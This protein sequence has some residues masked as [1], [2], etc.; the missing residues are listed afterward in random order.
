MP[1]LENRNSKSENRKSKVENRLMVIPAQAGI[2][3]LTG[4]RFLGATFR[5]AS[6]EFRVSNFDFEFRF[7]LLTPDSCFFT[8]IVPPSDIL[9]LAA[10][11]YFQTGKTPRPRSFPAPVHLVG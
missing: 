3:K 5:T 9:R 1:K 11:V 7:C 8:G 2:H 4:P 10:R 6:F